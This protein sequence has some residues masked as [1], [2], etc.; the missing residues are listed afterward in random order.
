MEGKSSDSRSCPIEQ[1]TQ[2][3]FY[4]RIESPFYATEYR[5][6]QTRIHTTSL[7]SIIAR[8]QQ[9][10]GESLKQLGN[11]LEDDRA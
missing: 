6:Y 10:M 4:W 2:L 5:D 11:L 9:G 8:K 7:Q 1:E 3:A